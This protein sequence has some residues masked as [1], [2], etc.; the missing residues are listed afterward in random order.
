MESRMNYQEIGR[1]ILQVMYGMERY[2]RECGL[3]S[4]LVHL[5]KVRASQ[6][7]GCAYCLD[8]HWKDAV[9]DGEKEQR[10]Y[11]L[12][13]WRETPYYTDRERA[14]LAWVESIT[15]IS[16]NH[17]PDELYEDV[18]KHFNEQELANLT[19]VAATINTWNRLVISARVVPGTYEP[20]KA[21][22]LR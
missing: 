15:F 8:M 9:A 7:N 4:K 3:D 12:E 19:F 22:V 16:S 2:I 6:M 17:V 20:A 1:G 21:T 10:L 11:S 5:M 18:R 14:A 13:A